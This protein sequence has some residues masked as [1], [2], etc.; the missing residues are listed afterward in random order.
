MSEHSGGYVELRKEKKE[1]IIKTVKVKYNDKK[2]IKACC[3][4]CGFLEIEQISDGI[5]CCKNPQCLKVTQLEPIREN[6]FEENEE[7]F[8]KEMEKVINGNKH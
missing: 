2:E 4:K 5:I 6:T 3:P 8:N 1:F 7:K